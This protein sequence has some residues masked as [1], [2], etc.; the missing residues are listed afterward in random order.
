MRWNSSSSDQ[1]RGEQEGEGAKNGNASSNTTPDSKSGFGFQS[2]SGLLRRAHDPKRVRTYES[3][4]KLEQPGPEI[5]VD[6]SDAGRQ[7]DE[8][9]WND[10]DGISVER[11]SVMNPVSDVA[12]KSV[13]LYRRKITPIPEVRNSRPSFVRVQTPPQN[14]SSFVFPATQQRRRRLENARKATSSPAPTLQV[15]NPFVRRRTEVGR[16]RNRGS[17][18]QQGAW[19]L[20]DEDLEPAIEP[21]QEVIQNGPIEST[22]IDAMAN[23]AAAY[24]KH[25]APTSSAARLTHVNSTGEAH[26]VDVG[27]KANSR[28]IAIASGVVYFSNPKPFQL[29][30]ENS[31]K[32]GDV[33]G[34]ARIAGIMAAK[35]TSDLIPLCHPLALSK[36][37]VDVK[38]HAPKTVALGWVNNPHGMVTIQAH[39]ETTGP[40][41]VEMEALTATSAAALTVYDMCKA[42][43]RSM[44]VTSIALRYKSGGKSGLFYDEVWAQHTGKTF[45]AE[46]SLEMPIIERWANVKSTAKS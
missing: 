17:G 33:L 15:P 25:S 11:S 46:R 20:T 6:T 12:D 45:F 2:L 34:V 37:D 28:R 19:G 23:P 3:R 38:L 24:S 22:D 42:V 30:F 10:R 7:S 31:N 40:T 5:S 13:T 29:I 18:N 27:A 36:A 26:M 41:G 43:D 8:Q 35:R 14:P 39:V 32:K 21:D 9:Q 16:T 44:R 1:N 4:D